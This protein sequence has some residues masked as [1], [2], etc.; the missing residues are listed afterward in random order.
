MV[1]H[2]KRKRPFLLNGLLLHHDNAR[3]HIAR[4]ALGA[5]QQNNVETLFQP[6]YNPDLT[7]C[8]FWLFSQLE[9]PL[10]VKRIASNQA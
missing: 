6:P 10:R 9:K 5:S 8:D 2:V 7:P 3:P 1:Q 4:C